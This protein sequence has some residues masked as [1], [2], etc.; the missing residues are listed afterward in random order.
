LHKKLRQREVPEVGCAA[1]IQKLNDLGLL[2]DAHYAETMARNEANY[3]HA[4]SRLIGL[5]LRQKGIAPSLINHALN[6]EGGD[7]PEEF[8]RALYHAKQYQ[9]RHADQAWREF[10]QKL[11]GYL[12]RKGFPAPVI[13]RV[14]EDL[15]QNLEA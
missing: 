15:S 5:K 12:Y 8:D 11:A 9:S 7:I 3:R 4:S 13:R 1:I 6:Q 2:N 14:I 10:R